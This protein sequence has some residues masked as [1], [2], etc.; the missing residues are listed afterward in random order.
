MDDDVLCSIVCLLLSSGS[1]PS[2]FGVL[3]RKFC[4]PIIFGIMPASAHAGSLSDSD[5][6]VVLGHV[7][8]SL[9]ESRDRAVRA[10]LRRKASSSLAAPG[11]TRLAQGRPRRC[12]TDASRG[13]ARCAL[14]AP[15]STSSTP[16]AR[17]AFSSA[18]AVNSGLP[19]RGS[20]APMLLLLSFNFTFPPML[21]LLFKRTSAGVGHGRKPVWLRRSVRA[22][23]RTICRHFTCTSASIVD[24]HSLPLFSFSAI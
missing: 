1:S 12:H 23:W 9:A 2:L 17:R 24:Y 19:R 16:P 5:P 14:R 8:P 7:S 10:R 21:P 15:S 4:H 11:C 18:S 20:F 13:P 22:R 6:T 3:D